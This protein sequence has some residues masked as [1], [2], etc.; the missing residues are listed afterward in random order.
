M[1]KVKKVEQAIEPVSSVVKMYNEQKNKYADIHKDEVTNAKKS[2]Y[3][4]AG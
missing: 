2:G 4:I 3:Q 1:I